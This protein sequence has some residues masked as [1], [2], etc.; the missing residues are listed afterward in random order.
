MD[1][2]PTLPDVLPARHPDLE[3]AEFDTEY[4]IFDPR[5]SEV[6]LIEGVTAIVFDACDGSTPLADL[7]EEFSDVLGID[8]SVVRI[9]VA[10][11]LVALASVGA[12]EGTTP[13]E[14]PP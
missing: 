11:A 2:S 8:A 9:Q 7:V 12:L 10:E 6:H 13:T 5:C 1:G 4:V 3:V 14:R